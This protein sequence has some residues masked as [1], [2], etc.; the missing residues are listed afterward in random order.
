[1]SDWSDNLVRER[2]AQDEQV[3]IEN[4]S[5]L[6]NRRKIAENAET[7]WQAV[8][9]LINSFAE[10]L[11]ASW[12][13]KV[14]N[15][16]NDTSHQCSITVGTHRDVISFIAGDH[17]LSVPFH[18][19]RLKLQVNSGDKLSWQSESESSRW[20]D[21]ESVA[22]STIEFVWRNRNL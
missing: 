9:K 6:S 11:D 5:R 4:E 7:E 17:Q 18:G 14:A 2:K 1:M 16:V 10:E 3:R 8:R 13:S 19:C 15:V 21:N 20:W 22:R 12:G